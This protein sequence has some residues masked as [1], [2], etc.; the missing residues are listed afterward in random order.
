MPLHLRPLF[1]PGKF[2]FL[3]DYVDRGMSSLE[4]VAYLFGLKVRVCDMG[5]PAWI[6]HMSHL[7]PFP[8]FGL[9]VRVVH[10]WLARLDTPASSHI[11]ARQFLQLLYPNKIFLLRG[12]HET[13]DVNGW[14]DHYKEKSFLFQ[15]K[16]RFGE[17][18]GEYIWEECNRVFDRLPLSAV[19]DHEIFCIHGGIPRPVAEHETEVQAIMSVPKVRRW[20]AWKRR[21]AP[22][23]AS[24]P[25][26]VSTL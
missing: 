19:I 11:Q 16:M 24:Q 23:Q 10:H 4:C 25:L 17:A 8:L 12:N 26:L 14:E 22:V 20:P 1:H 7:S 5:G 15:C 3:G 6:T 9:Q 13:R 21:R 18:K 2:L